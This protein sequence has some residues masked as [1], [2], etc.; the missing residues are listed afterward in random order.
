MKRRILC[1]FLAA[2]LLAAVLPLSVSAYGHLATNPLPDGLY[3]SW[4]QTDERWKDLV[5]GRDPW[6]D[7]AGNRHEDETVGH[8]GCLITSMA[9]LTRAY[10][11]TLTGGKEITPGTLAVAMY[12]GGSCKYLTEAGGARYETAFNTLIPGVKFAAFE[13]PGN[14]ATRIGQLLSNGEKEYI[15]VIGVNGN[16]H[17]VAADYVKDG[18]VYICDPGYNR[19]SLSEYNPSCLLVFTVDEQYVDP[20]ERPAESTLWV[21]T[22]ADGV[23]V[24]TGPG[25]NYDRLFVY[26]KGTQFEVFETTAADGYL[27]ART[28]DGWCALRTLDGGDVF[29]VPAN[30]TETYPVT[31]HTN[32][33][34]GGPDAQS[35][36]AGTDLRLSDVI[37]TKTG[38]RFLGWSP[39]PSAVS[40]EYVPGGWYR[41]DASLVLYAVWMAESD[42]FGFGIDV[43]EYQGTVN[44]NAVAADGI[45]FVILRAGTSRGK[46]AKFEENYLGAKAA[47][48]HVGSYFYS[49]ALTD[50]EAERDAELFR[51]WLAE[52][53]FDMPVYLD[54]E[55]NEQALLSSER[56]VQ[57][58]LHFQH[59]MADTGLLCGVYSS[60]SWFRT[61]LDSD[62][63]G[64][65][66]ALWVAKW[67]DSGTLSQ[68]MSEAYGLYQYSE[69]GRVAGI[70]T[71]VDLDICYI[72]YPA[73]LA[74]EW[75]GGPE[76]LPLK[77]GSGLQVQEDVIFGGKPGMT[78]QEWAALFDGDVT[79]RNADGT[80]M[81]ANEVVITGCA[82]D[83]GNR[84]YPIGVR[85]D[86]TGDGIV[87]SMDYLLVKRY[88]L[89]TYALEGACY[90]AGCLSSQNIDATDY[91]LLKR[92]VLGTFDLYETAE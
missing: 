62:R 63:L 48:L 12:D 21:V 26:G 75:Q 53:E 13:Q 33:G 32:G 46:D 77:A 66:E 85:G 1:F 50:A 17:Y 11:L 88:V 23:R 14:Y 57:L 37:P 80:L 7:A 71:T 5:I 31:Y 70:D 44:W 25:L 29:C 89:G 45:S 3:K 84:K 65:R 60:E 49:Y 42:I 69:T 87:D 55:T 90:Y 59:V 43:S 73:L 20:G 39:D 83:Y 30:P 54:L 67:T 40:A 18:K 35:K 72:D 36:I 61:R 78:V 86:V 82:L 24:R 28:P 51:E 16:R 79:F 9:I 91:A 15:I 4:K 22:D 34:T 19:T 58:A 74:G 52:K 6:V 41:Q 56:L 92:Y 8:A 76:K 27:W 47:G 38:Y 68:N 64:G 81:E 10:G 2:V